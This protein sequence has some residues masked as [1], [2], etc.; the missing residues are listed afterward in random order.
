MSIENIESNSSTLSAEQIKEKT[1]ALKMKI[2]EFDKK[3]KEDVK[4][5]MN[6][7]EDVIQE[8]KDNES[9]I[10]EMKINMAYFEDLQKNPE[11]VSEDILK[12]YEEIK[13]IFND[14]SKRKDDLQGMINTIEANDEI[15]G[16][17]REEA[18]EINE[19][20]SK[21]EKMGFKSEFAPVETLNEIEIVEVKNEEEFDQNHYEAWINGKKLPDLPSRFLNLRKGFSKYPTEIQID[22]KFIFIDPDKP[23]VKYPEIVNERDDSVLLNGRKIRGNDILFSDGHN[24]R[25]DLE[26]DKFAY[27][28]KEGDFYVNDHQWSKGAD[29]YAKFDAKYNNVA[30]FRS[31]EVIVNDK[32]WQMPNSDKF[33]NLNEPTSTELRIISGD[34]NKNTVAAV[35][36]ARRNVFSLDPLDKEDE[37]RS[38]QTVLMGDLHGAKKQW[39]NNWDS[40]KKIVVDSKT[41]S[42][43]VVA[44]RD[45]I[46]NII[47]INDVEVSTQKPI[48]EIERFRMEDGSLYIQY[49]TSLSG[50]VVAEK[51]TL[52]P[53]AQEAFNNRIKEQQDEELLKSLRTE[54]L[55]KNVNLEDLLKALPENE[56]LKEELKNAE[57]SS[58][59]YY[60]KS[61]EY[62]ESKEQLEKDLE[63]ERKEKKNNMDVYQEKVSNL[64]SIISNLPEKKIGSGYS[65]SKEDH[66][67]LIKLLK[68]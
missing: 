49:K 34:F 45:K 22:Q 17:V 56:K 41:D 65:L 25:F 30:L 62:K 12:E 14:L 7:R 53:N 48:A 15:M 33:N 37:H 61:S 2:K 51:I 31:R 6:K 55:S 54:I 24:I 52:T 3:K 39:N 29:R 26:N 8:I 58:N 47:V 16:S 63:K 5:Q 59:L 19:Q 21:N 57:S 1:E 46:E 36:D 11:L 68:E 32:L 67:K 27:F 38:G 40:I 43:A 4:K 23:E 13:G 66:D 64:L 20:R 9:L 28:N 18:G 60:E 50:E 10:E 44:N 35:I 42:V